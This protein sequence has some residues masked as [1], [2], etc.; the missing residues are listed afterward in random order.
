MKAIKMRA[1]S[2]SFSLLLVLISVYHPPSHHNTHGSST[3]STQVPPRRTPAQFFPLIFPSNTHPFDW[4]RA[5]MFGHI[6]SI[7]RFLYFFLF[8]F[9]LSPPRRALFLLTLKY[10]SPF[11]IHCLPNTSTFA[12]PTADTWTSKSQSLITIQI[13]RLYY[14]LYDCQLVNLLIINHLYSKRTNEL[15]RS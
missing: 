12:K 1:S 10:E 6:P 2:F 15:L 7:L 9:F 11:P 4:W 3:H 8:S 14:Y 5:R 13:I